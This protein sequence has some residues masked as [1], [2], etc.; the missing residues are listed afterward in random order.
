[1]TI[2]PNVKKE[3]GQDSGEKNIEIEIA[4]KLWDVTFLSLSQPSWRF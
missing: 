4:S 3:L 1:M 2:V